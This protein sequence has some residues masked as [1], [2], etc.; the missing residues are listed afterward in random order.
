M[1]YFYVGASERSDMKLAGQIKLRF[2]YIN[3]MHLFILNK[4]WSGSHCFK[5]GY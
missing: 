4:C 5:L 3:S 2:I 1:H